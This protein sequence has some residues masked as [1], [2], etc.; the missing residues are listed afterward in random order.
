MKGATRSGARQRRREPGRQAFVW[1]LGL[2][3]LA[4]ALVPAAQAIPLERLAAA[5]PGPGG[6]TI[7]IC[8]TLGGSRVVAA[9]GSELPQPPTRAD[10]CLVCQGLALGIAL[11]P[12]AAGLAPL[13]A[14]PAP[15]PAARPGERP[16]GRCPATVSARDPPAPSVAA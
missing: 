2:A 4:R 10:D 12:S 8:S 6:A 15:P 3:L 14:A 11:A 1:L 7:V 16:G 5:A 13:A 9:D